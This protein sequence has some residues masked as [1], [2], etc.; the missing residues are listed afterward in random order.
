[1]EIKK[2]FVDDIPILELTGRF[3][4]GADAPRRPLRALVAELAMDG[5][6]NVLLDVARLTDIDAHGLGELAW[7]SS[8]L[9]RAGGRLALIGPRG[10]VRRLISLTRLDTAITVY[11]SE[12]EATARALETV[13]LG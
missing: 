6:V 2:R 11:D 12:A 3:V 10:W 13:C 7:S 1:V 8:A 9:R 5:R 4:L